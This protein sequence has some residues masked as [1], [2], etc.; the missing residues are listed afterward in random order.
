MPR[1][2]RAVHWYAI[3]IAIVA[4][5][6]IVKVLVSGALAAGEPVRVT[7][8]FNLVLVHNPGAAF[9]LLAAAGGW[10]RGFLLAVAAAAS[11]WIVWLL[12]RHADSTLFAAA[13]T[14]ILGGAIGNAIDRLHAGAVIDFF[15]LHAFGYH[16]P[17][18]NVADA[19][20]TCGA[21]LLIADSL[22]TRPDAAAG[23]IDP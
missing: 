8:F 11:V 2:A 5:D 7:G 1:P 15:D 18:F 20:I 16:W 12:R 23:R 21:A 19:A 22:R 13:L 14:L 4:V 3:A 6:Q 10:Q 17:A 9:G